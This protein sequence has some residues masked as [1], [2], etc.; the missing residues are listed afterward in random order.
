M[1]TT[2]TS[3]VT[4]YGY[5]CEDEVDYSDSDNDQ[6]KRD[7]IVGT[8][9]RKES[10]GVGKHSVSRTP[11]QLN[12]SDIRSDLPKRRLVSIHNSSM[13]AFD[14]HSTFCNSADIVLIQEDTVEQRKRSQGTLERVP[15]TRSGYA[16]NPSNKLCRDVNT[17]RGCDFGSN[18]FN[19]HKHEGIECFK[20]RERR[21]CPNKICVFLHE[22]DRP[23][24]YH[25]ASFKRY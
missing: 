21:N 10:T 20:A 23:P 2:P 7:A 19:P 24:R 18:C 1:P 16:R 6:D 17:S 12:G 4:A 11:E 5:P 9:D 14:R 15:P 25:C 8:L 3:G 13:K 22:D